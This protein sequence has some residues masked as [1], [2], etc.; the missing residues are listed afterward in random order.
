VD[1]S[2]DALGLLGGDG[3]RE[4]IG[5]QQ[6]MFGAFGNGEGRVVAVAQEDGF[7]AEMAAQGL[8]DEVLAFD[9][10]ESGGGSAGAGEGGAEFL[11]V[12]VLATFNETEAGAKRAGGHRGDFTLPLRGGGGERFSRSILA[13]TAI[14][15]GQVVLAVSHPSL[16]S[17]WG[18]HV[19][20]D[21]TSHN[22][23]G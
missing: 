17:G 13:G 9:G 22:Q 6:E 1:E 3:A 4:D 21:A 19:G 20:G 15:E 14:V 2:G 23:T 10:D 5:R 11:D 16:R 8:G 12:R 7:E 18:T